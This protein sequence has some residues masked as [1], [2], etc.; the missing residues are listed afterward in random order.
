MGNFFIRRPIVA[1]VLSIVMVIVGVV[2]LT[3]LPIAQYPEITPPLIQVTTTFVGASALDVEQSVATPIEQQVNGVEQSIY[4]KSTN[5]NDGTLKL[6]VSFEVGSD[7]DISNVLTQN[8]VS[9]ATPS[10]PSDVKNYGVSV[11][12]SL[13]FPLMLVTLTSPSG[14]YDSNFLSNYALIN[15][16]DQLAR[17]GGVGQVTLFGGSDYAMRIW[18]RPDKLQ[19][20]GLTVTDLL[21][22]VR[23]Q[24]V[25]LPSGQI[26]GPPAPKGTEFTYQVRTQGRLLTPEEFGKIIVRANPDGSVVRLS[27][28]AR[29]ELG[30]VLYNAVGR[31]NGKSGAVI[32]IYQIPGSNALEVQKAVR[33]TMAEVEQRFPAGI[34]QQITLDTTA[35]ISAGVDEIVHTLFEAVLLV[36]LVVFI[37]LQNW[38]ATLIPLL[39]VPVSL[40]GTFMVF[41]LLGFSVN[42]LSLLGLVLAIG[43]VVDDAI[44]VVEAVM[45]HIE[46]GMTPK[47]ATAQAM[48]EVSGPVIAIALVLSAVFV[49]VAFISGITGRLYQQFAITIA[50]SVLFSAINALTLSPALSSLLLKPA[51]GKKSLLTPFYNGFNKLFGKFTDGYLSLTGI[52]VRKAFRSSVL[53]LVV[54]VLAGLVAKQIPGGFVPDED[55]GY[56]FA[57]IQLPDASSL[58]RT[59]AVAKRVE[60]LIGKAPGVEYVTT[61]TGYSLVSGAYAS[62]TAFLF[63]S[64]KP[65]EERTSKEE[66]A[67]ALMEALNKQLAAEVPEALAVTFGPPPIIGL[68]SGSGYTI[69]LQDRSGATPQF[70][71]EHTGRFIEA[72]RKRPEIGSARTVYRAAVPQIYA[73]IDRDKVTKLGVPVTDVNSTLGAL[74]GGTYVNDFNRFGRTYK[75]Y[76]Q[77]EPEYRADVKGLGLFAVRTGEGGTVPLDTLVTTRSAAGPEFTNRFNLYRAAEITGQPAPGYSS[78]Q[79]LD[80]LEQVAKEVLPPEMGYAWSNVSYQEKKAAGT[81]GIVFAFA[82]VLVFL[83]LAAQYESWSL[84]MSVMLGTPFAA[85]GAFLGLW[86]MRFGSPAY[87]NNVFAQIGLVML[88]GLAAKN[89]I[90]IVEFAKEAREKR[91]LGAMEAAMEAAKLR[92]RPILMTAFAFI[93]GVVPLVRAA[94]AGAEGRKVMGIAVFAGMLV[95]TILGVI[96]V[97]VL[98]VVIER[99]FGGKKGEAPPTAAEPEPR[100]AAGGHA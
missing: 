19:G 11:K 65:W 31:L 4:L 87:V 75:V 79:A 89:A 45:H 47:E 97:P 7:L 29:I 46:H 78:S 5:A 26:G 69:M 43:I 56:F 84:P 92:L 59:D 100:K 13:S 24:N 37:F 85:F 60:A 55:N 93:L 74:L 50:I 91:G 95:A 51:S 88:V 27:D 10:L 99:L 81:A 77:A 76:L 16:N 80:A 33:A 3:R 14:T 12:K 58:E 17:I 57:N 63:V 8:R 25:L 6:E 18:V 21:D 70:L 36:I 96:L 9:Q 1:M 42:T 39:T 44:V 22:A 30:S 98:F 53:V 38:R 68:G 61:I 34:Q 41:P 52:L 64:L 20:L 2:A 73:D 32:A 54:A 86:L 82:I 71:A 40:L 35:A 94:G 62:N 66:H 67:F 15:I 90:L 83:V 72:A 23:T 48:K 28:V 49:P